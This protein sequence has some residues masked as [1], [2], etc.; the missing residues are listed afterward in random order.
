MQYLTF[1]CFHTCISLWTLNNRIFVF[2]KCEF[3]VLRLKLWLPF[4]LSRC[5]DWIFWR[6]LIRAIA[7]PLLRPHDVSVQMCFHCSAPVEESRN[8][9]KEAGQ[10]VFMNQILEFDVLISDGGKELYRKNIQLE[11]PQCWVWLK[12]A[13]FNV[14]GNLFL[15]LSAS[16][17]W[18]EWIVITEI[19]TI[20]QHGIFEVQR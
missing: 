11:L 7:V 10:V 19:L 20:N 15:T 18:S 17:C 9:N 6:S 13:I 8:K 3:C 12:S 1:E 5:Y 16:M 4:F 2:R 14:V